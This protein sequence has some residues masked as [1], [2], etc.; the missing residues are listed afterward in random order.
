[1]LYML[2]QELL[3]PH[4][5]DFESFK[6]SFQDFY[7]MPLF[8]GPHFKA[9]KLTFISYQFCFLFACY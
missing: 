6:N 4:V 1:M 3:P 8:A 7:C 5:N 9:L 2:L